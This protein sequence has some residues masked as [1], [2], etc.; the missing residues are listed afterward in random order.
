[1]NSANTRNRTSSKHCADDI[2]DNATAENVDRNKT[3]IEKTDDGPNENF[4]KHRS[5]Q[6]TYF[7]TCLTNI[8]SKAARE[9]SPSALYSSFY[10]PYA[11]FG[12][13]SRGHDVTPYVI[14]RLCMLPDGL[15][16][17]SNSFLTHT[18]SKAL[19]YSRSFDSHL[20][21]SSLHM[22]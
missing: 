18:D 19:T 15:S 1:M 17:F 3:H 6:D 9:H 4:Q 5:H 21:Q 8:S 20:L 14:P 22:K 16:A 2:Y 11:R 12:A 7:S 10:H 13:S